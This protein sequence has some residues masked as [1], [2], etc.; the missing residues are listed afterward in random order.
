MPAINHRGNLCSAVTPENIKRVIRLVE[1][2][3]WI[4]TYALF[5]LQDVFL[6]DERKAGIFLVL[7]TSKQLVWLRRELPGF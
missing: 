5:E 7:S 1:E 3:G 6:K 2:R 4:S